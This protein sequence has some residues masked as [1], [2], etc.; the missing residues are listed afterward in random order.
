M[1]RPA[2]FSS[3]A[4]SNTARDRAIVRQIASVCALEPFLDVEIETGQP[5]ILWHREA[6]SSCAL[7]LRAPTEPSAQLLLSAG[8][9]IVRL[10]YRAGI[11]PHGGTVLL[12]NI[13]APRLAGPVLPKPQAVS[14]G[15]FGSLQ[16]NTFSDGHP[17][18]SVDPVRKMIIR[19]V[20]KWLF[21]QCRIYRS[22]LRF[23]IRVT[24]AAISA[25]LIAQLFALPLHGLWVVLTA[26]VVTQLSVGGSVRASA[27]YVIGTLGGAVYAGLVG[28]LLPY[29]TVAEQVGVLAV[30][31]APLAFVAALN[32]NFRVA[33]FSAVLVLLISGQLD[34]GPIESALIRFFEVT[35]GGAVAVIVSL[36]VIP[37]RAD[38][39]ARET[40]ARVLDEMAKDLPAI[41][42]GPSRGADRTELQA[43]QDRIGRSVAA[44]QDVV[45]EIK[46]ERPVTFSAAPDPGP[47]P[48]TLLRLRHDIVMM[49][50]VSADPLPAQLSE[51]LTPTLDRIG[52]ALSLY[53]RACALALTSRRMLPPIE[54]LQLELGAYASELDTLSHRELPHLSASQ[55]E[56]VF[57]LGFALQQLQRNIADLA[58][59]V[60]EW[61]TSP[62]TR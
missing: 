21:T 30:T 37:V 41:L 24:V 17:A 23:C 18:S 32:P 28:V 50:R 15:R 13:A 49:G 60:R 8:Q 39:L 35:L 54:P 42:A 53:F 40:A 14:V 48:R 11:W 31:I 6:L 56:Q 55:I 25:L 5:V 27:E 4:T 22:Q 12:V 3:I 59:C 38:R 51:G 7:A 46:R 61:T 1:N 36:L 34:E 45:E 33:P 2:G 29:A 9:R 16:Y 10:C 26:T 58:R 20:R 43:M 52:Q 62:A 47:L 19:A 57:A 44:L